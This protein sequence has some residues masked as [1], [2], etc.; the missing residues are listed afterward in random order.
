MKEIPLSKGKAFAIV[1]DEDYDELMKY[2]WSVITSP[3]KTKTLYAK[4]SCREGG[5]RVNIYMHNVILPPP[6]GHTV[7]HEDRNGLNNQRYN[8]RFA[9]PRQNSVNCSRPNQIYRGVYTLK[10]SKPYSAG[11][12]VNRR[13]IFIHGFSSKEEAAKAY[14]SLAVEYNGEFAV[15]NF[16]DETPN[17]LSYYKKDKERL[18]EE[19]VLA[20]R[21]AYS[22]EKDYSVIAKTFNTNYEHVRRIIKRDRWSHI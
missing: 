12:K 13:V 16:P 17:P 22:T 2:N 5:K 8:L 9:T 20:I 3:A 19:Q 14:D 10:T 18:T 4:R 1:D 21:E 6:D 15:L 11:V 7:D